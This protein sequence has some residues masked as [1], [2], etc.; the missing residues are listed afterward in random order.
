MTVSVRTFDHVGLNV[1]D[2]AEAVA[3]FV[4]VFGAN[5]LYRFDR[6]NDPALMENEIGVHPA[7]S[8]QAAMLELTPAVHVELFQWRS[9]GQPTAMPSPA[10]A[11]PTGLRSKAR[12]VPSKRYSSSW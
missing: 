10:D 6:E 5:E 8:F 4:S 7:A 11:R 1:P 2:L 12:A 9:P 3:F